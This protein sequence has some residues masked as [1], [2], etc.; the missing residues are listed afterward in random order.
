MKISEKVIWFG[1]GMILSIAVGGVI[2]LKQQNDSD[3]SP[4][5]KYTIVPDIEVA[6]P[7][8]A[9][10][11]ENAPPKNIPGSK[12][13]QNKPDT[14]LASAI[15]KPPISD[16]SITPP[17]NPPVPESPETNSP[18]DSAPKSK[19]EDPPAKVAELTNAEEK[20][21][22]KPIEKKPPPPPP[23]EY[24]LKSG[25]NP[26]LI[27]QK[28]GISTEELLKENKNLNPKNLQ[29]GQV[30]KLPKNARVQSEEDELK[31][32]SPAKKPPETTKE[33]EETP[34]KGSFEWYTIKN[35]ENP[36]TISRKLKVD[37]QQIMELNKDLNFRDLKIGQKIKVPKKK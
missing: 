6:P 13:D 20:P 2:M 17:T 1:L 3:K 28:F 24:A 33:P 15:P 25:D 4:G 18:T 9:T 14:T 31:K 7:E 36:W 5:E 23:T 26:W 12:P 29:I 8:I 37:H 27:A 34:A 22:P 35:G 30:L 32:T 11:L 21:K 10:P 16:P 19:Q